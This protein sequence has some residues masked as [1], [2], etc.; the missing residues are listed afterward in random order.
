MLPYASTRSCDA[1]SL[2]LSSQT[3][4]RFSRSSRWSLQRPPVVPPRTPVAATAASHC[5]SC[6]LPRTARRLSR[7]AAED[8]D[9]VQ[10]EGAAAAAGEDASGDEADAAG[11]EVAL[12]GEEEADVA[13]EEEAGGDAAAGGD[14]AAA[15]EDAGGEEAARFDVTACVAAVHADIAGEDAGE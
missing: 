5:D 2:R 3:T 11:K 9:G 6:R 10:E 7:V 13:Q 15:G 1:A 12:D 14:G 4:R 8:A